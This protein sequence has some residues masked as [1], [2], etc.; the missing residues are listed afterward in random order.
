MLKRQFKNRSDIPDFTAHS[1][2]DLQQAV[3]LFDRLAANRDIPYGQLQSG[4][5]ERAIVMCD[6]MMKAGYV[7]KKAWLF[8]EDSD[9]NFK[10]QQG[11]TIYWWYHVAPA[12]EVR[13]PNGTS[14]SLVIDPSLYDGPVRLR[15]W[16][17]PMIDDRTAPM[18]RL[19]TQHNACLYK[20]RKKDFEICDP[21]RWRHEVDAS[22]RKFESVP[23]LPFDR[24]VHKTSLRR[25]FALMTRRKILPQ[26]RTYVAGAAK[27]HNNLPH[28]LPMIRNG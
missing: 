7:P 16:C 10:S 17:R 2:P 28:N 12:L 19:L 5:H 27:R 21:K 4:C 9:L 25:A 13:M 26:K 14:Q 24:A 8:F 1:L 18:D 23:F 20:T 22:K 15:D 11:E 3:D 6:L